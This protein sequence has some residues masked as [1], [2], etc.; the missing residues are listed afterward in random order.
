MPQ[1]S[2]DSY[3]S[4]QQRKAQHI[5]E[6]LRQNMIALRNRGFNQRAV[7]FVSDAVLRETAQHTRRPKTG[8]LFSGWGDLHRPPATGRSEGRV[9]SAA[10]KLLNHSQVL[11][12]RRP[13]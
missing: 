4:K 6:G 2:K 7:E 3:T 13:H 1:G 12:Q 10:G 5:G 8:P 9:F 11:F